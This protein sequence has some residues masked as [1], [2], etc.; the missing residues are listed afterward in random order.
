MLII[1]TK[2]TI[3]PQLTNLYGVNFLLTNKSLTLVST[4]KPKLFF[5]MID[6]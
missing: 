5:E 6:I 3:I 1:I 2:L 4:K